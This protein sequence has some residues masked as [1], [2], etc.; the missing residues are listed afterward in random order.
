MHTDLEVSKIEKEIHNQLPKEYRDFFLKCRFPVEFD[1]MIQIRVDPSIPGAGGGWLPFGDF[2]SLKNDS[3]YNILENVN[4]YSGRIPENLLPIAD[5]PGGNQLC[6]GVRG[7]EKGKVYY[8]D[9]DYESEDDIYF[10]ANSFTE[11]IDLLEIDDSLPNEDDVQ[12][13]IW[14]AD[15]LLPP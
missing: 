15:D 4:C 8:W 1:N 3:N 12:A 9:H 5:S 11:F 13:D 6:I 14:L 2:Y 10:L 7:S